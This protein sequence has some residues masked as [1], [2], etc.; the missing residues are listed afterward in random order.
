MFETEPSELDYN[1]EYMKLHS[2]RKMF[3][4]LEQV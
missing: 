2:D 1:Y 3:W 4:G